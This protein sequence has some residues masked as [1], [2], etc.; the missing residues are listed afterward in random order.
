MYRLIALLAVLVAT[1][2]QA[3]LKRPS[4]VITLTPEGR[5]AIAVDAVVSSSGDLHLI[6]VEK[7]SVPKIDKSGHAHNSA[8]ELHHVRVDARTGVVEEAV[9]VNQQAGEV[10]AFSRAKPVLQIDSRN[11]LHVLYTANAQ[12]EDGRSGVVA[13]YTKSSD[14]GQSWR[15]AKTLNRKATN[16]LRGI[17]HGGFAA[18]HTFGTLAVD[19]KDRVHAY[20]IDTRDMTKDQTDGSVYAVTSEDHGDT[21]SS[22]R[23]IFQNDVCPC[24][25]LTALPYESGIVLGSRQVFEGNFRDPT[26]AMSSDGARFADRSRLGEGRWQLDG[27]P[28]K[29]IAMAANGQ[30]VVAAYFTLGEA[31]PGVYRVSSQDGG[32]TYST[33]TRWDTLAEASDMPDVAAVGPD[34]FIGVWQA[35]TDAGKTLLWAPLDKSGDPIGPARAVHSHAGTPSFPVL[36]AT[37]NNQAWLLWLESGRV[38][39]RILNG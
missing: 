13:R 33:A 19:A 7:V 14:G 30:S 6:W 20:W 1:A 23:A 28:L 18:A 17:L 21:F 31:V 34:Q 3:P 22:D 12:D 39:A 27:C 36:V 8:D 25:Q 5:K 15:A 16:D 35:T 32:A 29:P 4:G 10:W 11:D 26:L 37:D 38:H 9:R 2:C 24:C